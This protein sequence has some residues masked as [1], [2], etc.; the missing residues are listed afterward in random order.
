[1][2]ATFDESKFGSGE[3]GLTQK[4][5]VP[6]LAKWVNV[7]LVQSGAKPQLAGD[8]PGPYP[9]TELG[10]YRFLSPKP[11]KGRILGPDFEI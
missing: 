6:S 9:N 8:V 1:M 10:S 2:V 7:Y 11:N 4:A 5:L 3:Y